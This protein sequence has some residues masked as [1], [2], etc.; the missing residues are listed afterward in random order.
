MGKSLFLRLLLVLGMM[1]GALPAGAATLYGD[2]YARVGVPDLP[3]AVAFFTDVLDC[4][5][6]ESTAG[7]AVNGSLRPSRL[8][9]CDSGSIVELF[10]QRNVAAAP[11]QAGQTVRFV[12]DDLTHDGQWLRRQG[13]DVSGAPH[14]LTSGPLAGRL[15]L[16]FVSPWGL[17]LQLLGSSVDG[18]A[19]GTLATTDIPS[20]G[21]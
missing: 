11:E 8:L 17:H 9:I 10:D 2:D 5:P 19:G 16:D 15:A 4:R 7:R 21:N 12:T 1:V 6:I 18:S 13:V 20:G 14:R 3:Q